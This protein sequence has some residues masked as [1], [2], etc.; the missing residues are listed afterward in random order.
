MIRP[1]NLAMRL[2]KEVKS[3]LTLPVGKEMILQADDKK[4]SRGLLV[5]LLK[6]KSYDIAYW[7]GDEAKPYPIEVLVDGKS[8]SKDAKRVT[9]KF[10]PELKKSSEPMDIAMQL[11][12][13]MYHGT[14]ASSQNL[15]EQ[16]I[17]P[18]AEAPAT[19]MGVNMALYRNWHDKHHGV[20]PEENTQEY[21]DKLQA[22]ANRVWL[23]QS[24]AN[25]NEYA[26]P[27]RGIGNR[28]FSTTTPQVATV[29][30]TGLP[31][32]DFGGTRGMAVQGAIPA[33][34]IQSLTPYEE[35]PNALYTGEPMDISMRLLK[36]DFYFAPSTQSYGMGGGGEAGIFIPP[37]IEQ[38]TVQP[39]Q[40][41][42]WWQGAP[43]PSR[44]EATDAQGNYV[45]VIESQ[46]DASQP[47]NRRKDSG[48]RLGGLTDDGSMRQ[49]RTQQLDKEGNPIG[50]EPFTQEEKEARGLN[51]EWDPDA[52]EGKGNF[53]RG[54]S[55]PNVR[56]VNTDLVDATSRPVTEHKGKQKELR[57]DRDKKSWEA[58]HQ[59]PVRLNQPEDFESF[60]GTNLTALGAALH[61]A[62][63]PTGSLHAPVPMTEDE[64]FDRILEIAH[65]ESGHAAIDEALREAIINEQGT[66]PANWPDESLAGK[67][68]PKLP[69]KNLSVAHETGAHAIDSFGDEEK[70]SDRMAGHST[71]G[72]MRN[73]HKHSKSLR[74]PMSLRMPK[75]HIRPSL[76]EQGKINVV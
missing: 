75:P 65:H 69:P 2:L 74:K 50:G 51:L 24:K 49:V 52:N 38:N 30:E 3:D 42:G 60:T 1:M 16:G 11:L 58:T 68:V 37:A 14:H 41:I 64:V 45:N 26:N 7:Y 73:R 19:Q 54:G 34:N 36:S 9:M 5:E 4:H 53:R 17:Q 59:L 40:Q 13:E 48:R 57:F 46:F 23:E 55:L 29:D 39:V 15:M 47:F 21:H 35:D 25:A 56:V 62:E 71:T 8:V 72:V 27:K 20:K 31:M 18:P 33:A 44:Q 10:H 70:A 61:E 76:D 67:P 43:S 6:D 32:E 66:Y 63:N 12:K 22:N 28:S